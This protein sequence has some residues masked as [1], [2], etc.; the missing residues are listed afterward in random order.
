[1]SLLKDV[2]VEIQFIDPVADRFVGYGAQFSSLTRRVTVSEAGTAA[3]FAAGMLGLLLFSGAGL[4][5]SNVDG[6]CPKGSR[7][8]TGI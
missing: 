5:R 6:A 4:R 3:L 2:Q 7:M 8:K 1:L